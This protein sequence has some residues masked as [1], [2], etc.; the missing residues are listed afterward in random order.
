F[1]MGLAQAG[2]MPSVA[3]AIGDWFP[4]RE[5]GLASAAIGL[6][7]SA[8]SIL[9]TGLT[10]QLLAYAGWRPILFSYAVFG[11]LTAIVFYLWFRNTPA[12][13]HATNDAERALIA[14]GHLV[15]SSEP[16]KPL[17]RTAGT[18]LALIML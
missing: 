4:D 5:R 1:A 11:T 18:E 8:G 12:E 3:K 14:G 2:M 17:V 16:G 7:M 9:A 13:Q 15:A 6:A 10:A